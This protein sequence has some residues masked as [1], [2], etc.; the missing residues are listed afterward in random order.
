MCVCT[1]WVGVFVFLNAL[2]HQAL[3]RTLDFDVQRMPAPPL[4]F[5]FFRLFIL[6]YI[7]FK[8]ECLLFAFCVRVCIYVLLDLKL[9]IESFRAT[10]CSFLISFYCLHF[11]GHEH[12]CIHLFVHTSFISV[13]TYAYTS[14]YVFVRSTASISQPTSL[15][16]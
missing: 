7:R 1:K 2:R 8:A 6:A 16:L 15:M 4:I 13:H 14:I 3:H 11:D 9:K 5:L 12:T 10:Q